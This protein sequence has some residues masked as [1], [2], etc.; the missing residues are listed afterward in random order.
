[1]LGSR[2]YWPSATPNCAAHV[3]SL[4]YV[5]EKTAT[6]VADNSRIILGLYEAVAQEC[7][8][9]YINPIANCAYPAG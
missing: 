6:A 2:S 4:N 7:P 9:A 8:Q 5:T 3:G 1:M